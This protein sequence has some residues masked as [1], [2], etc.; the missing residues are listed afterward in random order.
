EGQSAALSLRARGRSGSLRLRSHRES[1]AVRRHQPRHAA[2]VDLGSVL[3]R[4]SDQLDGVELAASRQVRH[5]FEEVLET[6]G[7]DDL[8]DAGWSVTSVPKRVPL[9]S[10]FEDQVTNLAVDDFAPEIR[11]HA[12]LEHKAVLVLAT[13]PVHRCGQCARLH[14]VLHQRETATGLGSVNHETNAYPSQLSELS[15]PRTHDSS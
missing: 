8:E 1:D 3:G 11:A 14:R 13:V 10:R 2:E 4:Q 12:A 6:R 7:R 9:V 15:V 5:L